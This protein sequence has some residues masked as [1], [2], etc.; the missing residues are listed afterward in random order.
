MSLK[1]NIVANYIGNFLAV[2]VNALLV[3]I[4]LEYLSIEEYGVITFFSTL[5]SAFVILDMGLGL[6]VNKVASSL[7]KKD[8]KETEIL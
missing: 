5:T 6:T 8:S 1:K 3:P 4:Y 2:L 7:A